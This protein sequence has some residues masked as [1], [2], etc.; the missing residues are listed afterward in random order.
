MDK[1]LAIL[2]TTVILS[3]CMATRH[4]INSGA[5][6]TARH[7]ALICDG[8]QSI[9][10]DFSEGQALLEYGAIS[11]QL[12]QQPTASGIHY[13]GGGHDLRGKGPDMTW[14]DATGAVHQ[15]RDQQAT[16]RQP[17]VSG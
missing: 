11:V 8:G 13:A 6:P 4:F 3:G 12:A 17:K 14:T 10:V 2:A 16:T 7:V 5:Q 1:L 15:C 9:T